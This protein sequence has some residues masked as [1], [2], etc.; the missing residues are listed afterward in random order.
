MGLARPQIIK[1]KD[2]IKALKELENNKSISVELN[3]YPVVYIHTWKENGLNKV[4]V[5][6][7]R[8]IIQRTKQ[9]YEIGRV[10]KKRWQSHIN[11]NDSVL[12]VIGH[13]HFNKS[14]TLDVE[15]RLIHYLSG[16]SSIDKVFNYIVSYIFELPTLLMTIFNYLPDFMQ[17]GFLVITFAILF[18]FVL[19][20]IRIFREALAK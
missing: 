6:E 8:N 3:E 15:N 1:I 16:V 10:D 5:G 12:Y 4:Y 13:E 9:H 19:K 2:N 17:T 11:N 18:V 14:L 7:S 20:I